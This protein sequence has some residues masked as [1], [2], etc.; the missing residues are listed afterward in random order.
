[1]IATSAARADSIASFRYKMT[2]DNVK[3]YGYAL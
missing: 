2:P 3:T 1:M